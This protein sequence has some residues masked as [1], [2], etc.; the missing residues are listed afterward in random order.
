MHLKKL[1]KKKVHNSPQSHHHTKSQLCLKFCSEKISPTQIILLLSNIKKR[2]K[3]QNKILY[4][5]LNPKRNYA[6]NILTLSH[7]KTRAWNKNNYPTITPIKKMNNSSYLEC[8]RTK[9]LPSNW[10]FLPQNYFLLLPFSC[11]QK[12]VLNNTF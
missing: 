5:Y 9:I 2:T 10:E 7:H 12:I 6:T 1:Y 4:C 11:T 3:H 8:S